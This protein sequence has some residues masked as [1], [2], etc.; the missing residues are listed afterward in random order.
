MGD[1]AQQETEQVEPDLMM[2]QSVG[3]PKSLGG[4][5]GSLKS[6]VSGL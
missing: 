1:S 4:E 3:I 5:L 2:R 6:H